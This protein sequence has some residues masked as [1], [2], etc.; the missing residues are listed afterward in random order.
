MTQEFRLAIRRLRSSPLFS[1]S[2]CAA[3]G[4]T[5]AAI[6]AAGVLVYAILLAPLPYED[7]EE[8]VFV[9]MQ[10][11]RTGG[12]GP[13]TPGDYLD[14]REQAKTLALAAAA[15]AWSPVRSGENAAERITGLRVSGDL[16]SLL[17]VAPELGR[18]SSQPTIRPVPPR[19][20]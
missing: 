3:L 8:L 16:F 4:L 12:V 18:P 5:S 19:L 13:L 20:S 1:T 6:L 2:V 17:G 7:P 15:E 11:L 14:I 10:S 9:Q